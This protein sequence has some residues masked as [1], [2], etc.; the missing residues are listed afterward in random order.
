MLNKKARVVGNSLF[1]HY[2]EIGEVVTITGHFSRRYSK[3]H[4]GV[5][6]PCCTC[7]NENFTQLVAKV[8]LQEIGRNE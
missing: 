7:D 8:D 2:F 3:E 5:D 4:F 1:C 6:T